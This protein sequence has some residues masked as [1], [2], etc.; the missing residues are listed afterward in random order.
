MQ[1]FRSYYVDVNV[2]SWDF[3]S[4]VSSVYLL[5]FPN[6]TTDCN[7]NGI[8]DDNDIASGTSGDCNANGLP[9]ECESLGDADDDGDID[10]ELYT[11]L[12]ETDPP[13]GDPE[14]R[15]VSSATKMDI[16]SMTYTA[17]DNVGET[18]YI[19]VYLDPR[20]RVNTA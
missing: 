6:S 19:R 12:A 8:S 7:G 17:D 1:P 3:P 2:P 5:R 10:L 4:F 15:P 20:D 16:E 11:A 18:F 14:Q 9:D 13:L